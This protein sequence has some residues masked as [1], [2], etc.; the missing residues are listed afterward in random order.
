M[1]NSDRA[2]VGVAPVSI[3]MN[4]VAAARAKAQDMIT[5]NYFGHVSPTYGMPGQMLN[6]FGVNWRST[7]ENIAEVA[8]VYIADMDFLTSTEG[9]REI[10]LGSSF[11][12]VGVGVI[13]YNGSVVVVEEFVQI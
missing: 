11:N 2:N 1:I 12:Q 13:H 9:H 7:G 8:S 10:M 6:Q 5:K 3:N 4:A